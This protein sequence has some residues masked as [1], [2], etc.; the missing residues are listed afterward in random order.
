MSAARPFTPTSHLTALL[1]F[2]AESPSAKGTESLQ[3]GAIGA[4]RYGGVCPCLPSWDFLDLLLVSSA[5]PQSCVLSREEASCWFAPQTRGTVNRCKVSSTR[6]SPIHLEPHLPDGERTKWVSRAQGLVS[7]S[8]LGCRLCPS[9]N[10]SL[11]GAV[12]SLGIGTDTVARESRGPSC[13]LFCLVLTRVYLFPWHGSCP[14]PTVPI[15]L[16]LGNRVERL[17]LLFC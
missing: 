14:A 17:E 11:P 8:L 15:A 9:A 12:P 7:Q 3:T 1:L 16:H 4:A 6:W 10:G 13:L 2:T 5:H